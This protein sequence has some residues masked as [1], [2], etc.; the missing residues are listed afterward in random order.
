MSEELLNFLNSIAK[1]TTIEFRKKNKDS[2]EY[3][4]DL[5][6]IYDH[7]DGFSCPFMEIY[8]LNKIDTE[9]IPKW[10][11]F[12]FDGYFSYLLY[13]LDETENRFELWDHESGNEPEGSFN[14]IAE[15]AAG[16]Y[17]NYL[18][19]ESDNVYTIHNFSPDMKFIHLVQ[20][21]SR[22]IPGDYTVVRSAL[23]SLPITIQVETIHE[24]IEL[25]KLLKKH[26]ASYGVPPAKAEKQTNLLSRTG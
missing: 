18:E 14:S 9:S 20:S 5:G 23:K 21:Y 22:Y 26:G 7:Y 11:N 12:G 3:P 19:M 25:I 8:S 24:E 6:E 4:D 17:E 1:N 15:I 10:I 16:L 13:S 2:K